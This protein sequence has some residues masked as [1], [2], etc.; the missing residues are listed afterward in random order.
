MHI[1]DPEISFPGCPCYLVLHGLNVIFSTIQEI[2]THSA[3]FKVV[4]TSTE[5]SEL[6]VQP[7]SG[8][9]SL[10]NKPAGRLSGCFRGPK[11]LEGL[12][13][14]D[15][16][17]LCAQALTVPIYCITGY[18]SRTSVMINLYVSVNLFYG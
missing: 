18:P 17:W 15:L 13:F 2:E 14:G 16:D 3:F 1:T 9:V 10:K 7:G 8:I 4:Q 11:Y 12:L 6:S 5:I